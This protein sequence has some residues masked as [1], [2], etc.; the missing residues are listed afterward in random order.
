MPIYINGSTMATS[1]SP[2]GNG[3]AITKIYANGTQVWAK[4]TTQYNWTSCWTGELILAA[5]EDDVIIFMNGQGSNYSVNNTLTASTDVTGK[6][7]Y[8]VG[9]VSEYYYDVSTWTA[10]GV[11]QSSSQSAPTTSTS[12]A[13]PSIT[14]SYDTTLSVTGSGTAL[15]ASFTGYMRIYNGYIITIGLGTLTNVY[16]LSGTTTV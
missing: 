3:T 5:S 7:L 11:A 4:Q 12:T 6:S 15:T 2:Y 8:V 13:S 14:N 9:D 10:T 16:Y 1:A